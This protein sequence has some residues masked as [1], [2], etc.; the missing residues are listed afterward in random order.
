MPELPDPPSPAVGPSLTVHF[1][2]SSAKREDEE[3]GTEL[4]GLLTMHIV[5][6]I[7]QR[8]SPTGLHIPCYVTI[9]VP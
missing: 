1:L 5:T 8:P 6:V 4:R 7:K 2:Q 9:H 3:F